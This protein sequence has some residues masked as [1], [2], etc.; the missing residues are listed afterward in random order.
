MLLTSG[1]TYGLK[2]PVLIRNGQCCICCQMYSDGDL[3]TSCRHANLTKHSFHVSCIVTVTNIDIVQHKRRSC[4]Y[5]RI[6]ILGTNW[7]NIVRYSQC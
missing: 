7:N 5:C 4:P 2:T 1:K 3:I 6:N